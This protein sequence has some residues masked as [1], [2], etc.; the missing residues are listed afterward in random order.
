[1][2]Q[3][4]TAQLLREKMWAKA[5]HA[6]KGLAIS[7]GAR[8]GST[9]LQFLRIRCIVH[10]NFEFAVLTVVFWQRLG[11][12]LQLQVYPVTMFGVVL[13]LYCFSFACV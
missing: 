6:R 7:I 4:C 8:D 3:L 13:S 11:H 12:E 9:A 5:S 10:G 2:H 1:M